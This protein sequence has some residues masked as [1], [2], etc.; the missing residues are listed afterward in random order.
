M[1]KQLGGSDVSSKKSKQQAG[2]RTRMSYKAVSYSIF[3]KIEMSSGGIKGEL[4]TGFS[5]RTL[6]V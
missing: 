4:I 3:V 5:I 6:A 2:I 1:V